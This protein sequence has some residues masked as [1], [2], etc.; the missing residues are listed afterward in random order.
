MLSTYIKLFLKTKIGL[1]LV[2]LPN[3]LLDFQ[4]KIF[5]T[6]YF[7]NWLKFIAWLPLIL[8][9]LGNVCIA[10]ICCPVCDINFESNLNFQ[11]SSRFLHKQKVW[12]KVSISRKKWAFHMR[13]KKRF[14]LFLKSFQLA[15]FP[16]M[17][18]WSF[19]CAI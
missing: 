2:S 19:K 17:Q 16:Q 4:R 9:I 18:E 11:I 1:E 5:V 12:K 14:S 3:F 13:Y 8:E 15:K 7:I 10:I 6:L